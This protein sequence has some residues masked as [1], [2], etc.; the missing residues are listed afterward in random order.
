MPSAIAGLQAVTKRFG[1]T[2]ALDDVSLQLAGGTVH[3]LVGENGAGKST[4]VN[5]LSGVL[6]PD[7][8]SVTIDGEPTRLIAPSAAM[9][10]GIAT[11]YQERA[12]VSKLS[13]AENIALGREVTRG[14]FIQRK[15][16]DARARHLLAQVQ[17]AVHPRRAVASLSPAEQ[18]LVAI[19]KALSHDAR[20][21]ILDEPTAALTSDEAERL[22]AL[23]SELKAKG[24]A[25]LYITHRM[26]EVERLADAVTVLKDGRLVRTIEATGV[27][28]R[29][30]L[31]LIVR[32][33]IAQMCPE[34]AVPRDEIA[35][36]ACGARSRRR[37]AERLLPGQ[38]GRDR[39]RRGPRR[40]WEV[41]P[42]ARARW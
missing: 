10:R 37:A 34:P 19:A 5:I 1:S 14:G 33:E 32:R 7:V 29:D 31:P 16:A 23:L 18:Q 8:G 40:V 22:F 26:R 38:G 39:G 13:V 35:I 11:I 2:V 25:V 30:G 6:Q 20:V 15:H 28:R 4:I 36:E 41:R 9:H 27:T 12:L 42:G 21:L 24:L 3:A 17:L